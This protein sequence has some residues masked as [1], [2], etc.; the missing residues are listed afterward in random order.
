VEVEHVPWLLTERTPDGQRVVHEQ[1]GMATGGA[2]AG[3]ALTGTRL[4]E[5]GSAA[6]VPFARAQERHVD[7]EFHERPFAAPPFVDGG[8][9]RDPEYVHRTPS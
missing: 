4:E 6:R 9:V 7:A 1:R 3:D 5:H 2:H 8:A